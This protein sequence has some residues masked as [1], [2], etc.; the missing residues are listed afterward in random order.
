M[1]KILIASLLLALPLLT[2]CGGGSDLFN[3]DSGDT[4]YGYA[5]S[6]FTPATAVTMTSRDLRAIARPQA[7]GNFFVG[8]ANGLFYFNSADVTPVFQKVTDPGLPANLAQ[9]INCL[10][11]ESSGN[12]LIG[13][14]NGLFR[15]FTSTGSITE[16]LGL[17]GKRVL[18]IVEQ[19]SGTIWVG[20]EDLTASTTSIAR[21]KNGG[22]FTFWD[23]SSGM[24]AS[25]V[26]MIYSQSDLTI[27]CGRGDVGKAGLF[28][29]S[30][31]QNTFSPVDTPLAS[32]ATFFTR[33]GGVWYAG[34]PEADM[35]YS[36]DYGNSWKT[37]IAGVTPYCLV[38]SPFNELTS[39]WIATNKGLYLTFDMATFK[40]FNS[41]NR[42]SIEQCKS[43]WA[44]DTMVVIAHDGAAGGLSR[45]VYSGN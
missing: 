30:E 18:S 6:T 12:M 17:T 34:G 32:G 11:T 21:S 42:L 35:I 36:S 43:L 22:A 8:S 45:A 16:V 3:A 4:I 28:K 38:Q 25:S 10:A 19:A 20:L 14:D 26:I 33:L 41:A 24:T 40:L 2:A 29:F 7:N 9:A 37:L 15:Y 39:T 13:T 1:K 27:A 5:F 23:K 44:G 31:S